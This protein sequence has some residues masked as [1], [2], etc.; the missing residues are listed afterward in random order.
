MPIVGNGIDIHYYTQPVD[1][2]DQAMSLAEY[3]NQHGSLAYKDGDDQVIIPLQCSTTEQAAEQSATVFMLISGWRLY[4][5]HSDSGLFGLPIY[6][7]E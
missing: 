3:L 1:S 6:T 4:W 7:K 5:E 2:A